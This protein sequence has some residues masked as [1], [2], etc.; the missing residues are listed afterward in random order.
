MKQNRAFWLLGTGIVLGVAAL[1]GAFYAGPALLA[2]M[3]IENVVLSDGSEALQRW[4]VVPQPLNYYVYI[5]HV[6]NPEEVSK[7]AR[8]VVRERGPY[9]YDLFKERVDVQFHPEDDTVSYFDKT[10]YRFNQNKSGCHSDE[11]VVTI[12]NAPVLGTGLMLKKIMEV[13]MPIFNEAIPHIFPSAP[14]A[15]ITARVR[16]VLFDGVLV[17]CSHPFTFYPAGPVCQGMRTR[18]PVTFRREGQNYYF[19]LFNHLNGTDR[20]NR[21]RVS[22]GLRDPMSLGNIRR[23][24]NSSLHSAWRP[25]THCNMINGTDTTIFH[26]FIKPPGKM[27][28]FVSGSC[29]SMYVTFEK[30]VQY[31]GV[32]GL[33]YVADPKM[34]ASGRT[35]RPNRC[36]C[37]PA[38]PAPPGEDNA[39]AAVTSPS[40]A[41]AAE[42]E[43]STAQDAARRRRDV[44][45]DL[46]EQRDASTCLPDGSLDMTTCFGSPVILTLPHFYLGASEF[47]QYAIGLKADKAKHETFVDIEPMTGVPLRGGKRVQL[48]MFLKKME[49][50]D[51]LR[52]VSEGLFPIVWVDEGIELEGV[53]LDQIAS[54]TRRITFLR[55]LPW[56]LLGGAVVLAVAGCL[57]HVHSLGMLQR[58]RN[59]PQ[60]HEGPPLGPPP[61]NYG[62]ALGFARRGVLLGGGGDQ[63]GGGGGV[64]PILKAP[65]QTLH[66][67]KGLQVSDTKVGSWFNKQAKEGV[68]TFCN[69]VHPSKKA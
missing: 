41:P 56:V 69:N 23:F 27:P 21:V 43:A 53:S 25:G 22:R 10:H 30:A 12:L 40:A 57:L 45:E 65:L 2:K 54:A 28:V 36:F 35:Y 47:S 20:K 62:I 5:F 11:D 3:V 33:H 6:E 67:L 44:T 51:A 32:R 19:S 31:R 59:P 42:E 58:A 46:R 16:E 18:A 49:P 38:P 26:P 14:T 29:R 4:T 68:R 48:N 9:V 7:G 15:F 34:L 37:P 39:V 8:P 1:V 61:G 13:V 60:G 55:V 52:D 50:I 17:N 24:G 64:A 63:G 66:S